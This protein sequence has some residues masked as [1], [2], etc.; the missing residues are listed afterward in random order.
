[1]AIFFLLFIIQLNLIN[2]FTKKETT[3][4]YTRL[5]TPKLE[6][7]ILVN[8]NSIPFHFVIILSSVM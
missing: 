6:K 4:I 3:Q 2:L 8:H 1:M 7:I 5:E